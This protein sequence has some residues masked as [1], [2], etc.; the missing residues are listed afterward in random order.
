MQHGAFQCAPP[1]FSARQ[2]SFAAAWVLLLLALQ[3]GLLNPAACMIHCLRD[4]PAA[5]ES[6]PYAFF[7][8]VPEQYYPIAHDVP[9]VPTATPNPAGAPQA[10]YA[11]VLV[12]LTLIALL[13]IARVPV[14]RDRMI[15]T[16]YDEPP[17]VPPPKAC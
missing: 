17:L 1:T 12:T 8:L 7:C 16:Y 15:L 10:A 5:V 2:R 13:A 14:L 6:A 9:S 4:A 3:L 11:F